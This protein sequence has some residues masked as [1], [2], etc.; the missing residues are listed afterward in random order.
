MGEQGGNLQE[1]AAFLWMICYGLACGFLFDLL[2]FVR[3]LVRPGG[4][5]SFF[6][7]LF[8]CLAIGTG[9]LLFL[10]AGWHGDMR[11]YWVLGAILGFGVYHVGPGRAIRRALFRWAGKVRHG[12]GRIARNTEEKIDAFS[13]RSQKKM[14]EALARRRQKAEKAKAERRRKREKSKA[15]RLKKAEEAKARRMQKRKKETG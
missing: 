4:F 2:A 13:L 11:L 15:M 12:T 6:I 8:Y 9:F 5:S 14:D 10:Y 3:R 7:D 1:A